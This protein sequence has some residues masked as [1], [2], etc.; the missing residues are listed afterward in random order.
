MI[1][2]EFL[3]VVHLTQSISGATD[4][5]QVFSKK[6][7]SCHFLLGFIKWY[8]P[9]RKYAFFPEPKTLFDNKCLTDLA[10]VLHKLTHDHKKKNK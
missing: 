2:T 1:Q 3:R 5:Y 8:G 10:G 4:I 9:W 7:S 6:D